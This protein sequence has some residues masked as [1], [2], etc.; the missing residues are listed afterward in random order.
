MAVKAEPIPPGGRR[1]SLPRE[2]VR[3]LASC[4][5]EADIVQVLYAELHPEFGYDVINLQ[6]V[7]REGWY[8]EVP[9]DRG[10]LQDVRRRRLAD[11][12]F[13]PYY[14]RPRTVV[15]SDTASTIYS[16]G[17]GPGLK[18]RPQSYVWVPAL[19]RGQV[20]ASVSYQLYT[21]RQIPPDEVALLER[22]HEQLGVVVSNAYLNEM[23]RNQAISL[24]ALNAIARALSSTHRED[25]V[26]AALPATLTPLIPVERLELVVPADT[27]QDRLRLL[28]IDSSAEPMKLSLS[29]GSRRLRAAPDGLA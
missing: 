18:R 20:V 13:A 9:I 4:A 7:E 26:V 22:V 11:S 27:R 16:R 5:T 12:N 21:K 15:S 25:G 14:E 10:V 19:H 1:V 23:T 24:S 8:H 2:L 3:A 29:P 6:V 28:R 17:R